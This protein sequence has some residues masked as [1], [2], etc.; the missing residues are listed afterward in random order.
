MPQLNIESKKFKHLKTFVF[1]QSQ[2][3]ILLVEKNSN[4]D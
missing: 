3:E 1:L 2:E 4:A